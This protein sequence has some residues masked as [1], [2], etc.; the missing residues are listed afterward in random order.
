MEEIS[1]FSF[2]SCNHG[3]P[4]C[5]IYNGGAFRV[6]CAQGSLWRLVFCFLGKGFGNLGVLWGWNLLRNSSL[7]RMEEGVAFLGS[8]P[9]FPR[10]WLTFRVLWQLGVSGPQFL[11]L[12][13]VFILAVPGL[14]G[15]TWAFSS[16]SFRSC[17]TWA[18]LPWSM[19][20]LPGP[21]IELMSPTLAGRILTTRPPGKF[22]D[23][24]LRTYL[25]FW[26]WVF[27]FN[28]R[29]AVC[30]SQLIQIF[31]FLPFGFLYLLNMVVL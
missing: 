21:G 4:K 23:Q 1:W 29:G 18:Q 30:L 22:V 19:W 16:C 27:L 17:G 15:C 8:I 9:F 5:C 24:I 6:I 20:N 13:Y 31:S 2:W 28:C 26:M 11:K 7:V 14:R 10:D 12:L 3:L 25:T